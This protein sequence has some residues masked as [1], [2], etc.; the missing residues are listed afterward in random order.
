M[1][2]MR[3]KMDDGRDCTET[4]IVALHK[5][6]KQS[7]YGLAGVFVFAHSGILQESICRASKQSAGKKINNKQ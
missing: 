6:T 5:S 2:K 4:V 1:F 3:Q 7:E